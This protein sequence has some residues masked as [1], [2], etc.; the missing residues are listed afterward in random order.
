[1]NKFLIASFVP[2]VRSSSRGQVTSGHQRSSYCIFIPLVKF[3]GLGQ[4]TSGHQIS[5]HFQK[6]RSD[7]DPCD[8]DE[9]FLSDGFET[10]Y[11]A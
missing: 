9:E 5:S 10:V 7:L 11:A 4:V 3:L 8:K 2:L 6:S 1:M